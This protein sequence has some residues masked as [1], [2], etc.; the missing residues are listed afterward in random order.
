MKGTEAIA[1]ILKQEGAD[2]FFCFPSNPVIDAA[3]AAD[4]RPIMARTERAAV[5]M[6]DGYTRVTNGRK[7]G[8]VGVQDGPG[9]ESSFGG[10]A[11]AYSDSTPILVLPGLEGMHRLYRQPTFSAISSFR[12]ITKWAATITS[13]ER[14][15]EMM[16]RAFTYL[17]MGR[18]G[19]VLLEVPWPLKDTEIDESLVQYAPVKRA[20]TAADPEDVKA[21]VSAFLEA[22]VPLIHAGQG[23]LYAEASDELREFAELVQAPVMTTLPGKSGFPETHPLSV[24]TGGLSSAPGVTHFLHKADLIFG[25]GAS[26]TNVAFAAPLPEGRKIVQCTV[27]ERDVNKDYAV[28]QVLI[29]DAKLVLQQCITEA[30]RQLGSSNRQANDAL[31]REIQGVKDEWWANWGSKLTSDE[32]P[33]APYRVI[34]EMMNTLEAK[35]VIITHD[36]GTPRDM[37]APCWKSVSPRGYIG[38]GKS[39]HLGYGLGLA[40]GAKLAAP[41]KFVINFMGDGAFGMTGMDVETGVRNKIPILTIVLNNSCL[42]NYERYQPIANQRYRMRYFQ[43]DYRSVAQ[44]LGAY[45]ERVEKPEEIAP[46]LRRAHQMTADGKSV[47]LEIITREETML[48]PRS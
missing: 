36:S 20:R 38:W 28:V 22:R 44:G 11:Q 1:K 26:L 40:L 19:P 47:L 30:K 45:S 2:Y 46:A 42:G 15:P 35:D 9:I 7:I 34:W 17:R 24:G 5:A 43:G 27:D 18:P 16:R 33:L 25:I 32:V 6:A 39:T 48:L 12:D 10:I 31:V 4:I 14:V 41:E 3:A 8:V 29:G 23:V 21:A 37:L 13:I